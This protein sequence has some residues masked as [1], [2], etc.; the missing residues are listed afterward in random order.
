MQ[1]LFVVSSF[2]LSYHAQRI[3]NSIPHLIHCGLPLAEGG[4]CL[5]AHKVLAVDATAVIV[6]AQLVV[7]ERVIEGYSCGIKSP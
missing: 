1:P 7:D 5:V 3:T 2:L 4:E 6:E